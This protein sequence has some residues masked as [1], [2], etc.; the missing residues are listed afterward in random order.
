MIVNACAR[1]VTESEQ[2][3]DQTRSDP[4]RNIKIRLGLDALEDG[5]LLWVD[6]VR[7]SFQDFELREV[8]VLLPIGNRKVAGVCSLEIS[9]SLCLG[10]A[11]ISDLG[12]R[13]IL[14]VQLD[15]VVLFRL[16]RRLYDLFQFRRVQTLIINS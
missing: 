6:G 2:T 16:R 14:D 12:Y 13:D 9:G 11:L 15:N 10:L 1:E 7:E 8:K 4:K 3:E 5:H